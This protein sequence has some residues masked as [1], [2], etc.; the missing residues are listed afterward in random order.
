[1]DLDCSGFKQL[2]LF[3]ESILLKHLVKKMKAIALLSGGLDSASVARIILDQ[4]IEVEELKFT[5]IFCNC[6]NNENIKNYRRGIA[7]FL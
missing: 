7:A 5:S 2:K 6:D 3:E 1:L 4:G